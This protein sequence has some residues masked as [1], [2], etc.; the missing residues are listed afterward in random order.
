MDKGKRNTVIAI[1]LGAAVLILLLVFMPKSRTHNWLENY[2]GESKDPFGCYLISELIKKNPG[3]DFK[4]LRE[5][6]SRTFAGR[7]DTGISYIFIGEAMNLSTNDE[8][9]LLDFV[10]AGN[11]AFIA[12]KSYPSLVMSTV[13]SD[14]MCG[15][16]EGLSEYVSEEV[17]MNFYHPVLAREDSYK[18][19]FNIKEEKHPYN[20][21]VA[22]A[23]YFCEAD[24]NLVYVGFID[25]FYVNHFSFRYGKGKFF[26]HTNPIAF[27]NIL[28]KDT[29][30]FNYASQ[31]FSQM[32]L[33]NVYWDELSK[34]PYYD[35]DDQNSS[36][37]KYILSQPSLRAGWYV[38][39]A[40][41]V[42]Y[43]IF[44]AKRRQRII[45]VI[46]PH[47]NNTLA[48]L[49]TISLLYFRSGGHKELA[50]MKMKYFMAYL[51]ERYKI[52][53]TPDLALVPVISIKSGVDEKHVEFIFREYLQI[54]EMNDIASH[55]LEQFSQVIHRFYT[56]SK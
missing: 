17:S 49:K 44:R 15:P 32:P 21:R 37:L 1:A 25:S 34:V 51:R 7:Q 46:E 42:L 54:K 3:T 56:N 33:R 41:A 13:I 20:W 5:P 45:P 2:K 16:W 10:R 48:F 18:Y 11:T 40:L 31:V 19:K 35:K 39:I 29:D 36:P 38:L 22:D 28:M 47:V 12:A 26:F 6:L 43:T 14:T 52:N 30:H 24:T 50:E 8:L 55:R 27:T 23:K 53:G 4:K 9:R